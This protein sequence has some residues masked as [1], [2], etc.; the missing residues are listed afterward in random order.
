MIRP[1]VHD[2]IA[3]S[4]PSEPAVIADL[5]AAKDLLDTFLANRAG[6][7]GMAANMIGVQKRIIVLELFGAPLLMLNPVIDT[8]KGVY[9]TTEGC[10]SLPGQRETKRFREITVR[11]QDRSFCWHVQRLSGLP[12]QIV[13]HEIDHCNG[14]LI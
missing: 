9:Q 6:C 11:Y 10:L 2:P 3:L 12:A 13:Q 1:I 7:V 5:A 8:R 4:R 14:V